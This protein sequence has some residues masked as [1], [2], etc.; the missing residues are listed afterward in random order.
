MTANPYIIALR[1]SPS[2][3]QR[4]G[5]FRELRR[6]EFAAKRFREAGIMSFA[7]LFDGYAE[8][9]RMEIEALA[10]SD[11]RIAALDAKLSR[12]FCED[13]AEV[14]ASAIDRSALADPRFG[15]PL[16]VGRAAE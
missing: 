9:T 10:K 2:T 4:W 5:F 14:T 11:E 15:G 7:E 6:Y 13:D 12:R 8:Q 1:T 3:D 16:P